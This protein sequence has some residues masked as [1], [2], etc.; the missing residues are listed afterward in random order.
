MNMEEFIPEAIISLTIQGYTF[1]DWKLTALY[2]PDKK[3]YSMLSLEGYEQELWD[4]PEWLYGQLY[5]FLLTLKEGKPRFIDPELA[6]IVGYFF[7]AKDEA[8]E[9]LNILEEGKKI[10]WHKI[11]L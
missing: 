4:S 6:K 1:A 8:L 7:Y 9:V 5:P 10:G 3:Q 2:F 11:K